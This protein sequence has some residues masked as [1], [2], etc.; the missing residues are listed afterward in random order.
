MRRTVDRHHVV[1]RTDATIARRST[2]AKPG[3]DRVS[4]LRPR[5]T[6]DQ[7]NEPQTIEAR[8]ARPREEPRATPDTRGAA[9]GLAPGRDSPQVGHRRFASSRERRWPARCG[10]AREETSEPSPGWL[11]RRSSDSPPHSNGRSPDPP[12]GA[13]AAAGAVVVPASSGAPTAPSGPA[14]NGGSRGG[15]GGGGAERRG[16]SERRW[17][18]RWPASPNRKENGPSAADGG[19]VFFR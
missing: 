1:E 6:I 7:Q 9:G 18:G 10:R 16:E 4:G 17:W 5:R 19:P 13:T 3:T 14:W 2:E 12:T 11:A 8:R 15:G